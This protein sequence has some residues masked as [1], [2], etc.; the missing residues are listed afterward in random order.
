[1]ARIMVD[2]GHGGYDPGAI[3]SSGLREAD[4]N[5]AVAL[6]MADKLRIAGQEVRLTRESDQVDWERGEDLATRCALANSWGADY[7]VSIHANKYINPAANGTETY[8]YRF[9]GQGEQLARAIQAELIQA[10]GLTD[11]GVKQANF[12]VLAGTRM[13][14]VLV[15]LA[16]LSNSKEE[17]L[18]ADPAFQEVCAQAV[19][20]GLLSF[21]GVEVDPSVV[22]IRVGGKVL[23]GQLV[24]D[25][26]WGPVRAM[27]EALGKSVEWNERR[28]EVVIV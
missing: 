20:N 26:T 17:K 25:T 9:G 10:A 18:L 24:G 7:F 4:V 19:A 27:A 1:M 3:G 8:C 15:E 16:F 6:V 21:L 28:R 2:P 11:R 22:R 12:A 5:L 13:P 23:V 14:A